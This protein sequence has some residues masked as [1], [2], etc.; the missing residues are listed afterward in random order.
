MDFDGF[1]AVYS[2]LRQNGLTAEPPGRSCAGFP[3]KTGS[4]TC[5]GPPP[6]RY[7]KRR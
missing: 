6:P 3:L 5:L 1:P 7:P 2:V 4:P